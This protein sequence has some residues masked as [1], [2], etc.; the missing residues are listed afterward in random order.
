MWRPAYS[1][2]IL[3]NF[4]TFSH[5]SALSTMSLPNS[6]GEPTSAVPQQ[7]SG[8]IRLEAREPDHHGSDGNGEGPSR[9][10]V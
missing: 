4:T 8:S 6:A 5:Y 9:G 3:A 2:F 10:I 7:P 1:V